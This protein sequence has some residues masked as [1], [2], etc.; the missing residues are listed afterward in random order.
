MRISKR[1]EDN[2]HRKSLQIAVHRMGLSGEHE[3]WNE[4]LKFYDADLFFDPDS[5]P[6]PA[7]IQFITS[8]NKKDDSRK[9]ALFLN[10]SRPLVCDYSCKYPN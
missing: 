3:T 9:L 6:D 7:L 5:R 8:I 10:P 2:L 1:E 4:F